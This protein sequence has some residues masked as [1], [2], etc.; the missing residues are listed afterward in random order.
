MYLMFAVSQKMD[1]LGQKACLCLLEKLI[2]C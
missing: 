1:P 2:Y